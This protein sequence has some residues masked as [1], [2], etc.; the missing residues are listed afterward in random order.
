MILFTD[1][2]AYSEKIFNIK[3]HWQKEPLNHKHTVINMLKKDLFNSTTIYSTIIAK[4]SLWEYIFI[5]EHA[6]QSQFTALNKVLKSHAFPEGVLCLAQSGD[7]FKGYRERKWISLNGNL[8]LSLFLNP[9][10]KVPFFNVGFT[11][12]ATIALIETIDS[13]EELKNKSFIKWVN[14]IFI[15]GNKVAGVLTQTQT[16]GDVV[17]GIF[18]GIGL[19]VLSTPHLEN[20]LIIPQAGS[21]KDFLKNKKL[22][23]ESNILLLLLEKLTDNYALLLKGGYYDLLDKYRSRS[24]IINKKVQVYSDPLDNNSQITHQ[25]I[26]R[27]IGD[28]LEL[29]L[30]NHTEPIRSGRVKL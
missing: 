27:K 17:C 21:L 23:N 2:P 13:I 7:N 14:D 30:D 3:P 26:V 11:I 12:L 4:K 24:L 9:N 6:T 20:D 19:N 10:Q 16:K 25:G 29:Y 5:K 18:I 15:D 1:T 28:N 22:L 8:H